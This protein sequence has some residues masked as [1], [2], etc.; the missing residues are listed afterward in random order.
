MDFTEFVWFVEQP[1]GESTTST[2]TPLKSGLLDPLGKGIL[3]PFRRTVHAD[4]AIASGIVLILS[5]IGQLLGTPIRRLPWRH[6]F[7]A[8]LQPLR[9]KNNTELLAELARDRVESAIRKWAVNVQ[10]RGV[11]AERPTPNTLILWVTLV[12]GGQTKTI[13]VPVGGKPT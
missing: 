4:F 11:R 13:R 1:A 6:D 9:H 2:T 3:R 7:G 5:D 12:I 8:D 10:L